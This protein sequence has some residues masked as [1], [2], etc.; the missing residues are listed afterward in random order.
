MKNVRFVSWLVALVLAAFMVVIAP[1][2]HNYFSIVHANQLRHANQASALPNAQQ[3]AAD[4]HR[5][6]DAGG[7]ATV[8]AQ[9]PGA[10]PADS[11]PLI[12]LPG[13]LYPGADLN[14][15]AVGDLNGDGKP[16][17]AATSDVGIA[18][19][20]GNG[21][22]TF[23]P[24]VYYGPGGYGSS[25]AIADVNGDGYPDL[26]ET[27]QCYG[28]C[29]GVY[30][31]LGNGDGT[32]Q[33]G[34][35]YTARGSYP[36]SLAVGDLN[37]DGHPDL[38]VATF[39]DAAI[40]PH[41]SCHNGGIGVLLGNGDGTFQP[42]VNYQMG[43]YWGQSVA[44]ADVNHDGHADVI[45]VSQCTTNKCHNYEG[46]LSVF[47]GNGDGTLQPPVNYDSGGQLSS[48]VKIADLNGDGNS[49]LVVSNGCQYQPCNTFNGSVSVLLGSGD[50]SFGLPGNISSGGYETQSV[51]VADVNGDGHLDLVVANPCTLPVNRNNPRGCGLGSVGVLLGNGDG[52]FQNAVTY[53]SGDYASESA[54]IMDV[55]GDGKPDIVVVNGGGSVSV[56]LN[57][58]G[59][60]PS[61]TTLASSMNPVDINKAV[62]YT[63]TVST[64]G[65]GPLSGT[66]TFQDAGHQIA[67]V[68]VA[69]NQ[70]SFSTFYKGNQIGTHSITAVY[71]GELYVTTG[72]QAAYSEYIRETSK[73]TL[74]TSGSPSQIGQTVTFTA[75]VT[76]RFGAIP[77]GD[78]VTFYAAKATLGTS[79]T[80]NGVA[81]FTTSFSVAKTYGVKATYSGDYSFATSS[82]WVTQVVNP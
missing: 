23:Q 70:G 77:N 24:A 42:V 73:T 29:P 71:G 79:T 47:L 50:G 6:L 37:G 57:N 69:N 14:G 76:S 15:I 61:I 43:G 80:T 54:A 34:V 60:P 31:M 56:L 32:F 21:D 81:S 7:H 62:T 49:D 4:A 20:L 82:G 11:G 5:P 17:I 74:A 18:V 66:V 19:M 8:A 36:W 9:S 65:G 48:G 46:M 59:A 39:C 2:Q 78:T 40:D 3:P 33:P 64:G 51:A 30:V 16:D 38:V 58:I 12:F 44:I 52:S 45:A 1:T 22:G 55:N 41:G 72:S 25:V 13:V 26:I 27:E 68:P 10:F 75:T 63:A 67:D 28:N 53:N 35:S